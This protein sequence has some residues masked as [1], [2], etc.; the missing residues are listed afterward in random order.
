MRPGIQRLI[1]PVAIRFAGLVVVVL[2]CCFTRLL[3]AESQQ[4]E[5]VCRQ[6]LSA[7]HRDELAHK[8]RVIT[9]WRDLKFDSDGRLMPGADVADTGS[10]SARSLITRTLASD[11]VLILEDASARADV[12][13][14]HVVSGRWKSNA[15]ERRSVFVVLIDFADFDR[16]MGDRS[17]LE[18]FNVGWTLLHEIDHAVN[19]SV[20]SEV[21]GHVGECEDHINQMRRECHLPARSDYFFTLFPYSDQGNF[22]TRL[23]RLA[24]DQKEGSKKHRRFWVIW[25]AMLVGGL[26]SRRQ[27]AVLR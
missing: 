1:V 6:E 27:V 22:R 4:G 11:K 12:V 18:A 2:V 3:A 16:L 20:D 19:D 21:V 5:I 8:L 13:F 23:V 9:G 10:R 15:A 7:A 24:F 26:N 17:A 25:D 14:A